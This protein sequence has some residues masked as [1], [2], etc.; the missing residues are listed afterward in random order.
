[1]LHK[2]AERNYISDLRHG[3]LPSRAFPVPV[4]PP[5]SP[6]RF[7]QR[8]GGRQTSLAELLLL[9]AVAL[10]EIRQRP[11]SAPEM[12]IPAA[13]EFKGMIAAGVEVERRTPFHDTP[14]VISQYHHGLGLPMSPGLGQRLCCISHSRLRSFEVGFR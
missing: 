5:S 8:V 1:M 4:E 11:K 14:H 12:R 3:H 2:I 10:R 7:T 6:A 13:E 9:P